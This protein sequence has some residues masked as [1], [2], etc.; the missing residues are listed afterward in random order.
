MA[1]QDRSAELAERVQKAAQQRTP[2]SVQ[3]GGTKAF[4]GR[5]CAGEALALAEHQGVVYYEPSELVLTARA[6]TPLAQIEALLADHGQMLAFEPPHF[7]EAATLG[8]AIAT[9][10][11]G[12]RRPYAGAARDFVLGVQLINGR[13]EVL[14]FGG[15][16]MKN[17]AGYDLARTMT[18]ALGTLG[19]ILEVS[20]KVLPRPAHDLTLRMECKARDAV[21]SCNRWAGRPLPLSAACWDGQNLFVRLSGTEPGVRQAAKRIGGEPVAEAAGFWADLREHRHPFFAG[22]ASLWRL[23][24][25]PAASP[26]DLPGRWLID[27]G[28]AQR[29]LRTEAEAGQVR[30]AAGAAGGHA[31]W[32]RGG[33]ADRAVFHPLSPGLQALQGRLKDA[34]DPHRILNP[35]RLYPHW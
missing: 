30:E 34:L 32:L 8:G 26:L 3:G 20:V 10:L 27:W 6:G 24:L 35:G 9:G 18:G 19:V 23:S 11:S 31:T 22:A 33:P 16:V 5:A 7:G 14:R 28:G 29:W 13:G 12:P 17:V 2:L 21:A 25:P 1:D 4:Y 15:Q